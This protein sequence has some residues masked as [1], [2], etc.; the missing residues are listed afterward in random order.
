MPTWWLLRGGCTRSHSEHGRET[1]QR[2]WYSV[3]RRGRV[4]RCQV[5]KTQH[6]IQHLLK[7]KNKRP[8]G[9]S[10]AAHNAAFCVIKHKNANKAAHPIRCDPY[11]RQILKELLR[12]YASQQCC[13]AAAINPK[14]FNAGNNGLLPSAK[15][16]PKRHFAQGKSRKTQTLRV[17]SVATNQRFALVTRGG[18]A[19]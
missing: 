14:G 5:C 2:Q 16:G 12:H 17:C 9:Q 6:N 19:R 1:P 18:A 15:T 11:R 7:H 4:G 8:Q 13:D 10:K 3:L